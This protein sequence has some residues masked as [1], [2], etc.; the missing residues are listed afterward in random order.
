[1]LL[2]APYLAFALF[3]VAGSVITANN[4]QAEPPMVVL[5]LY[6]E[7]QHDALGKVRAV[8][9]AIVLL[10]TALYEGLL[11]SRDRDNM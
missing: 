9:T 8:F 10:A 2:I 7:L 6:C 1:M 5:G 4:M 11:S 3:G